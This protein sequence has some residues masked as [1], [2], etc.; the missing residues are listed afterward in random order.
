MA[1]YGGLENKVLGV[2]FAILAVILV[3][4]IIGQSA[5]V[6]LINNALTG[7]CNSGWPLASLF[8]PDGGIVPLIIVVGLLVA[9]I[10]G[11]LAIGQKMRAGK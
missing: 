7:I 4:M 10:A 5:M 3:L 9:S 1:T 2:V 11:A 8:N 6:T